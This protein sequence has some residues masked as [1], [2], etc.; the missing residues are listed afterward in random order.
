MQEGAR[1]SDAGSEMV[2][3]QDALPLATV[4][5][6]HGGLRR[7]AS[8][9]S[10]LSSTSSDTCQLLL[11]KQTRTPHTTT[12]K[13]T[14]GTDVIP[15][16]SGVQS[17]GQ[18]SSPGSLRSV[19]SRQNSDLICAGMGSAADGAPSRGAPS[20]SEWTVHDGQFFAASFF[21]NHPRAPQERRAQSSF[22]ELFPLNE[23]GRRFPSSS[24]FTIGERRPR[25]HNPSDRTH[26]PRSKRTP[27]T[28]FPPPYQPMPPYTARAASSGRRAATG[29]S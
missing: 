6:D 25:S 15:A 21:E 23:H 10:T 11:E 26:A 24:P 7:A 14:G 9:S 8:V 17:S 13:R 28:C 16:L 12:N 27:P 3:L 1:S 29:P 2:D 4:G 5:G 20:R 22:D 18:L 19:R